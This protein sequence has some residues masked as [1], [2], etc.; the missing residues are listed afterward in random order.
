[1]LRVPAEFSNI[2][3]LNPAH[4]PKRGRYGRR[5]TRFPSRKNHC[6]VPCDSLL[7]SDFC[8]LL[9]RDPRVVKYESHP[10]TVHSLEH[11]A[12]YTPD[13][14]VHYSNGDE[15]FYEVKITERMTSPRSVM[16]RTVFEPVFATCGAT[17][18]T[19]TSAQIQEGPSLVALEK[20]YQYAFHSTP[21]RAWPVVEKLH[22][23]SAGA[24]LSSLLDENITINEVAYGLFYQ[25]LATENYSNFSGSSIL[26]ANV[27]P[28]QF[29]R[30]LSQGV[31]P[32]WSHCDLHFPG[33]HADR[34]NIPR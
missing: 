10:V 25:L 1:M 24:P 33:L 12:R 22:P 21:Q 23:L 9:E 5:V 6:S 8:L 34:P 20:W 14:C 31:L 29:I 7:E 18:V 3:N 17:L 19:V 16:T 27:E 30:L 2:I 28:N 32:A 26:R 11:R 13:F 4:P 15:I